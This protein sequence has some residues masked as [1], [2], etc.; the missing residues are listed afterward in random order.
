MAR[1][2]HRALYLPKL[3]LLRLR[4]FLA[5]QQRGAVAAVVVAAVSVRH[6]VALK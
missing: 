2:Q 6:Q 5:R 4:R 1:Q 3:A